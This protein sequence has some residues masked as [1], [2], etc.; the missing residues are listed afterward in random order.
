MNKRNYVENLL[1]KSFTVTFDKGKKEKIGEVIFESDCLFTVQFDNYRESF[2]KND[3]KIGLVK[4]KDLNN[5][6]K[7]VPSL[8][9]AEIDSILDSINFEEYQPS[10]G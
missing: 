3:L 5:K 4:L 8:S 7:V 9:L 10:L 1:G 2:L 6:T